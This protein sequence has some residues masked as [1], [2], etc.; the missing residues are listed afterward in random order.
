MISGIFYWCPMLSHPIIFLFY[1]L[2]HGCKFLTGG[3]DFFTQQLAQYECIHPRRR[4]KANL[5]VA[6]SNIT[7]PIIEKVPLALLEG[8]PV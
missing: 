7:I 1:G 2:V 5:A 3:L 8:S 6:A 4:F